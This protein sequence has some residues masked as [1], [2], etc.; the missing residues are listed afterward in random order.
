MTKRK[1]S[2]NQTTLCLEEILHVYPLKLVAY[3][4]DQS[5]MQAVV[6]STGVAFEA[7]TH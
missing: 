1:E 5:F 4:I 7:N 3:D 6:Q 2:I